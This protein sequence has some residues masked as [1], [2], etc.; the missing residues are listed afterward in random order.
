MLEALIAVTIFSIGILG[1][2]GLQASVIN[3]T[4]DARYRTDAAFLANQIISQM[5]V[6][7]DSSVSPAVVNS[8]YACSPCTNANGNANTQAWV[9][10][11]QGG[12]LPAGPLGTE[13]QPSIAIA[14]NQVTVTVNWMSPQ[15]G[16]A[17]SYSTET[18]I[19]FN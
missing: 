3:N 13:N 12:F 17:H 11:I 7:P 18:Q 5:W 16:Q 10:E 14:G 6:D 4:L 15:S 9:A 19:Q 1:S 2:I 8:T